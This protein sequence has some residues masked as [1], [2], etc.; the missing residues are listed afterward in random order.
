MIA[1]AS[2]I[3]A[4]TDALQ[5]HDSLFCSVLPVAAAITVINWR[6]N[7]GHARMYAPATV[8]IVGTDIA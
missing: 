6:A 8:H 4:V 5:F 2:L 1:V 7:A 3:D